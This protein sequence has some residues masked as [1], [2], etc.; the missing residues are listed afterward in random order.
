VDVKKKRT[1]S[2]QHVAD[3][4][5]QYKWLTGGIYFIDVLPKSPSG[6]ILRRILR[7]RATG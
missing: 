1:F 5:S 7:E 2:I 4:K 3:V 6:K